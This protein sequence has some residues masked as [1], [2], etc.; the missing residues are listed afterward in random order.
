M[1]CDCSRPRNEFKPLV[2]ETK[3]EGEWAEVVALSTSRAYQIFQQKFEDY[4]H[5][6]L[7]M[8]H[9]DIR[10]KTKEELSNY[11]DKTKSL[12]ASI[13]TQYDESGKGEL[14]KAQ[15]QRMYLDLL[16]SQKKYLPSLL[17]EL[18]KELLEMTRQALEKVREDAELHPEFVEEL[19]AKV[20]DATTHEVEEMRQQMDDMIQD[21]HIHADR[22]WSELCSDGP[23]QRI[24][25][26]QFLERYDTVPKGFLKP[27]IIVDRLTGFMAQQQRQRQSVFQPMLSELADQEGVWAPLIANFLRR[28]H[29]VLQQAYQ[30][31]S[32]GT[33]LRMDMSPEAIQLTLKKQA[34]I[35]ETTNEDLYRRIFKQYSRVK[36]GYLTKE[37]CRELTL[38]L[39][40][41]EQKYVPR[42]FDALIQDLIEMVKRDAERPPPGFP[43]A[44]PDGFT[45]HW[46]VEMVADAAAQTMEELTT[47]LRHMVKDYV[48]ISDKLFARLDKQE[49]G[50]IASETFTAEFGELSLPLKLL[51]PEDVADHLRGI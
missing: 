9:K 49:T 30:D 39:L 7:E 45:D 18:Y 32:Q 27:E 1:G 34:N 16:L 38:E 28:T 29:Q 17:E 2:E 40:L 41:E 3:E 24:T 35:F 51:A 46:Y 5:H 11:E 13:W 20:T 50:F 8:N 14:S 37:E 21:Y 26:A 15:C 12:Y 22:V 36:D 6:P 48:D 23:D 31:D 4:L 43:I 25:R 42:L 47:S 33:E 10:L 44:I 19:M